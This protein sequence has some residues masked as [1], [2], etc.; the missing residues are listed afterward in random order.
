[1]AKK[2]TSEDPEN[3]QKIES[4]L[5]KAEQYIENNQKK[6]TYII[7]GLVLVIALFFMYKNRVVEPRNARAFEEIWGAE[8][9]FEV[10]SF[11]IALYGNENIFGFLDIISKYGSTKSG[12]LARYYAG[13]CYL[14]MGDNDNALKMLRAFKPSE[15]LMAQ[16]RANLIGDVHSNNENY[17]EA[18]KNYVRAAQISDSEE[19]SP[20]FLKKAG[21]CFEKL[22]DTKKALEVYT[23]IKEKYA[24]TE[25][26]RDID[27]YIVR[28]TL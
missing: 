12:N 4:S 8:R 22:G 21:L 14:R 15:A 17:S 19:F 27:K 1:M 25:V 28:V 5:T 23:Q 13:V 20:L 24:A 9:F 16:M 3:F 10:D 7:G 6:I 26:G 2:H 18:A 11:H